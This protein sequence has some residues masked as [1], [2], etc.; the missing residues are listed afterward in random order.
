MFTCNFYATY[1]N[2]S[3]SAVAMLLVLGTLVAMVC[4]RSS[5]RDSRLRNYKTL[6]NNEDYYEDDYLSTYPTSRKVSHNYHDEINLKDDKS[7][8]L[9]DYHDSESEEEEFTQQLKT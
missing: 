7:K 9:R 2:F 3:L 4:F 6:E 5:R 8:L 1:L